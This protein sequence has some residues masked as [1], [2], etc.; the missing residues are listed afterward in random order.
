MCDY[1]VVAQNQR[2]YRAG[3]RL[4]V[5]QFGPFTRGMASPG[6]LDTAV[7][8]RDQACLVVSGLLPWGFRRE[9]NLS[10]G[11]LNAIFM[12]LPN[13]E[14]THRDALMFENGR[15]I[16]VNDLPLGLKMDVYDPRAIVSS[17]AV[18]VE[19]VLVSVRR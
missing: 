4:I 12:Q 2:D 19:P 11:E 9:Y 3:E 17:P 7:C 14:E 16:L 18:V 8:I 1:S 6:D 13:R 15:T 5:T 10:K